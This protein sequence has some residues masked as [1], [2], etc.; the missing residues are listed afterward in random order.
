MGILME[1]DLKQRVE[2]KLN[3]GLLGLW[4]IIA[5]SSDVKSGRPYPVKALN[6]NLV[7]WRATDGAIKCIEDYCPHRG[8]KLSAGR[9]EGDHVACRYHGAELDGKGV[10]QRVPAYPNCALEGRK[11]VDAYD[12]FESN[13]AVFAFFPSA[14]RPTATAPTL[15]YELTNNEY[16]TFL[17]TSVWRCNYRYALEN[18]ADP[19]HG[20]YLHGDTFTLSGG[21][22]Q[23]EV[24]LTTE[25]D[26]FIVARKA[27]QGENFDW[28][29]IVTEAGLFYMR[30]NIPYPPAGGPGGIM[31]VVTCLTPIDENSCR[32]FFWRSRRVSGLARE[33]WR[34]MFRAALEERHWYVLEQDREMLESINPNARDREMLY[35]HDIGVTR[36]R[37]ILRSKAKAQIETEDE[38]ATV[39]ITE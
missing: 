39:A 24:E 9:V 20:P 11:A 23:D 15:P 28:A 26:G 12:V 27:Q 1:K 33:A 31:R 6:R 21:V 19:M 30:V 3:Q 5:K 35:Q 32:I 14:E 2:D 38:T 17:T 34:F 36:L 37:Q 29:Q 25:E 13:D 7:L 4:Y 8:A 22:K 18:V 16:A 10:V